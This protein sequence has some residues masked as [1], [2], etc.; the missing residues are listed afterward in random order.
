[1]KPS[2]A[3]EIGSL[4]SGSIGL[5]SRCEPG[6]AGKL[7]LCNPSNRIPIQSL[8]Q[9]ALSSI[10][11]YIQALVGRASP[12]STNIGLQKSLYIIAVAPER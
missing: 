2:R 7:M 1:M 3:E 6:L 4:P 11:A 9:I 10:P 5:Q 12:Y 8:Y